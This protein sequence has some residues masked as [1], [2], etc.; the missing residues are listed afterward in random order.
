[1]I[2]HFS[3]RQSSTADAAI[4]LRRP[5]QEL[6]TRWSICLL[7][8][9]WQQRLA[10]IRD[11]AKLNVTRN[12]A[13]QQLDQM[14]ADVLTAGIDVAICSEDIRGILQLPQWSGSGTIDDDFVS[15]SD[16]EHSLLEEL[17]S[18]VQQQ[19]DPTVESAERL[20]RV[21]D[22][23]GNLIA[24]RSNLLLQRWAVILACLSTIVAITAIIIASIQH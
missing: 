23:T 16:S 9:G 19:L 6:L 17:S 2:D 12:N 13:I 11:L 10:K 7:L 24:A 4:W 8:E 3:R 1:L 14:R 18:R 5:I 15:R 22:M 20:R 21:I